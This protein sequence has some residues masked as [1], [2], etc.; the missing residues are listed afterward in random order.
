MTTVAL[1]SGDGRVPSPPGTPAA[2][3]LLGLAGLGRDSGR[4]RFA[5]QLDVHRMLLDQ[6]RATMDVL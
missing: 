2:G 6:E 3:V 5:E 1:P 4:F